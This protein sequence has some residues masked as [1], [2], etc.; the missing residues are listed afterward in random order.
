[1]K[2]KLLL[3]FIVLFSS[4]IGVYVL[5][6]NRTPNHDSTTL[7]VGTAAGYAPFVSLD[8]HGEYEGF[9]ID[10]AHAL[11]IS[12]DKRLVIKD[13]GSMTSLVMALE[14][15]SIDAIIWGMSITQ[16][17]LKKFSMVHYQGANTTSYPL[18]FWQKIPAGITNLAEMRGKTICVEPAS[19]QST[20]LN[21]HSDIKTMSVERIDDAL[22]N[23]QYGKADAAL[24][25]PAIA[26][27]F[28][29]KFPELLSLEIP[30]DTQDQV[31]GV[32]IM[33]KKENSALITSIEQAVAGL[34][35]TGMIKDCEKKWGLE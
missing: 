30:L 20:F 31:H 4:I 28:K 5:I 25:D 11:A 16:D 2:S 29:N 26:K 35:R 6:K 8:V 22:L 14:Q 32:G 27:K 17:R 9:D 13:L 21:K 33:I 23:I 24:V 7:V 10:I 1:M 19:S 12:L 34:E 3:F 18:L 15:G